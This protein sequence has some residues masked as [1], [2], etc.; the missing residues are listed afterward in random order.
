[1]QNETVAA[2]I[3]GKNE[4]NFITVKNA[5]I[6]SVSIHGTDAKCRIYIT[7]DK[8]VDVT[9]EDGIVKGNTLH[10]SLYSL[11]GAMLD[12]DNLVLVPSILRNLTAEDWG[13]RKDSFTTTIVK[14]LVRNVI[15]I[16]YQIVPAGGNYVDN[17]GVIK[18]SPYSYDTV[19]YNMKFNK[20]HEKALNYADNL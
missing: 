1:M 8:T 19:F 14:L 3:N 12:N 10:I 15:D 7:T 11:Y 9:S 6:K 13:K 4:A 2:T 17:D 20:V 5:T 16:N 18:E